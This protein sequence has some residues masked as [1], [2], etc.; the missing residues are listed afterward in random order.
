MK[1]FDIVMKEIV[2]KT[3]EKAKGNENLVEDEAVPLCI[4]SQ[5]EIVTPEIER[6]AG[7]DC[8]EAIAAWRAKAEATTTPEETVLLQ[9]SKL[10]C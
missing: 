6:H 2:E 4:M 9:K 7:D 3:T 5:E 10:Q 8:N 1:I